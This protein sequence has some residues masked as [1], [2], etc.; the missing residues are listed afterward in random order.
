MAQWKMSD[1]PTESFLAGD[2]KSGMLQLGRWVLLE[3]RLLEESMMMCSCT[4]Y[5]VALNKPE[6]EAKAR[7][8]TPRSQRDTSAE[9]GKD[10][11]SIHQF[12]SM[13][14]CQMI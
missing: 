10:L 13:H 9:D 7:G 14:N 4:S 6:K 12:T 8:G 11:I 3:S 5:E 2:R 1:W